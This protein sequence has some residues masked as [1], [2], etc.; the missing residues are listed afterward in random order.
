MWRSLAL[1]SLLVCA[2][3]TAQ[4]VAFNG[5]LGAQAAVLMIDGQPRTVRLG[6]A[7][8]GVR[9]VS[10][11]SDRAVVEVAGARRSLTLGATP[12][13]VSGGS[14]ASIGRQI[15]MS[16]GP[17]GHFTTTGTINGKTTRFM[18]D[19]GATAVAIG[20]QE[21]EAM[22]LKFRAGR[23]VVAQTANGRAQ[24][25]LITLSVLRIGDVEVHN[26]EAVVVPSQMS[27]V[28]L[29][30]SFLSRFQMHR[31]NDI[32]TLNLRY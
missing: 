32:L 15:V 13:S 11:E 8:Q 20:Q 3:A 17:G 1:L 12:A 30:N 31:D 16:S 25:W 19:T 2:S 27:H 26:V 23:H 29:G 21:A 14:E 10:L 18:V 9:L 4:Q 28:L 7:V 6:E 22:G 24:A 5:S